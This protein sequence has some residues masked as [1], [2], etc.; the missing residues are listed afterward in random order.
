MKFTKI[1]ATVSDFRCST[2]FLRDIINAGV[3]VIR[4]NSA[5]ASY[6]GLVKIVNNVREVDKSVAIM[7]DT[8][9]PEIRTTPTTDNLK[10]HFKEGDEVV[11]SRKSETLTD[12]CT[13]GFTYPLLAEMLEEN[14]RIIIDDGELTLRVNAK[15]DLKTTA[16]V[17]NDGYLGSRKTVNV[18]GLEIPLPSVTE[19]DR[20]FIGYAK[21]LNVDFIAHSFV[22]TASD[23]RDVKRVLK[24]LGCDIKI[25]SKIENQQGIDNFNEILDE[26]YGIMVARGDL[27]IEVPAEKI[28]GIQMTLIDKCIKAHK[29]VIVATQMLHSMI[30]HS[31]PTRAEVSDVANAVYQRTDAIMLSGETASGKYPVEAVRTMSAIA[32]EVENNL[33]GKTGIPPLDDQ[34]INSFLSRQAVISETAVGSEA[35]ITDAHH[36]LT[37]RYIASFRGQNPTIA[38]CY[39]DKVQ[40]IL[41]LSYG[42]TAYLVEDRC[43]NN[44]ITAT[45]V[46]HIIANSNL[47][48][49][50]IVAYISG[51]KCS[52][53][54]LK[55]D[56]LKNIRDESCSIQ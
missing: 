29:P 17:E 31:R 11:L 38:I 45:V 34:Q 30:E 8:K 51:N 25:I 53:N 39:N 1:V 55:I 23:V 43:G 46:D 18:P 40:R 49:D 44:E 19:R 36:G 28:P 48:P 6:E 41:A 27:G 26:S 21:E 15:S 42:V 3:N 32:R 37:A 5:H 50:S 20:K 7:V 14:S 12:N 16:I 10:I 9:G 13:I 35:V 33:S 22:R 2:D 4:I 56:S 24:E 47:R 52:A 54:A